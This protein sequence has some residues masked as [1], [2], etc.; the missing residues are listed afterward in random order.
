MSSIYSTQD[1]TAERDMTVFTGGDSLYSPQAE[2][3]PV[4]LDS[5]SSYCAAWQKWSLSCTAWLGEMFQ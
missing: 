2:C 1:Q 4:A 3:L 5:N